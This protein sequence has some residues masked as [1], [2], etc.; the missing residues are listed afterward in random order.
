M[1]PS[2]I[3]LFLKTEMVWIG[4]QVTYGEHPYNARFLFQLLILVIDEV[5]GGSARSQH[6]PSSRCADFFLELTS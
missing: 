6:Y 2:E 4:N 5:S 3:Y 1:W